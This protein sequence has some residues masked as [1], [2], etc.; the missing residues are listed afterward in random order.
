MK[1]KCD[2][3]CVTCP[4][5]SQIHCAL[6]YAKANNQMMA[7]MSDRISKVES[8]MGG[9]AKLINPLQDSEIPPAP[10]VEE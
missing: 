5:Q 4:M 3:V 6:I 10:E 8:R 7:D 9:E 2:N 1:E